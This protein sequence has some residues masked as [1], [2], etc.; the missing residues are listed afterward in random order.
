MIGI[1]LLLIVFGVFGYFILKS[2]YKKM[3]EVKTSDNKTSEIVI[4]E[5]KNPAFHLFLYLVAFLALG[6]LVA[7]EIIVFFQMINKF[8]P[9]PQSLHL[10]YSYVYYDNDALK[11]GLS[12]LIVALPIYFFVLM[13]IEKKLGKNE[14]GAV[15]LVRKF[16]TYLAM[17]AFSGMAIG[18]LISLL[19]NY[20]DGELTT[21]FVLKALV[22][23]AVSIIFFGFYFWE[24]RRKEIVRKPFIFFYSGLLV[25]AIISVV[26]GFVVIDNPKVT[27]EKKIDN[28]LVDKMNTFTF[29]V[30]SYYKEHKKLPNTDEKSLNRTNG[31]ITYKP[32]EDHTY[33]LCG[34]FLRAT[35]GNES[36]RYSDEWP[37]S[38]GEHCFLFDATRETYD[39]A[40]IKLNNT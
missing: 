12:A 31:E 28:E 17:F 10:D 4:E 23:F 9:D 15:S 34:D 8:V 36:R 3:E 38:A 27:R 40:P 39:N 20:F 22:F 1:L 14:I 37:H 33:E 19:Y 25:F 2:E 7:G 26:L 24:I 30:N 13:L 11:F 35:D 21:R 6:F 16:I 32:G 5:K 29:G 18:S